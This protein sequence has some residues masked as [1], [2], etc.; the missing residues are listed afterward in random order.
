MGGNFVSISSVAHADFMEKL[1]RSF[2][3]TQMTYKIRGART[4]MVFSIE[5][6]HGGFRERGEWCKKF[7]E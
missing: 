3:M 4:V 7:R 5:A 2:E 6:L 1:L